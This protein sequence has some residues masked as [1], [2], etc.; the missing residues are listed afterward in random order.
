VLISSHILSEIALTCD[1]VLIIHNGA[2]VYEGS[3]S[4][5]G[6]ALGSGA[7]LTMTLNGRTSAIEEALSASEHVEGYEIGETADGFVM[8]R[9]TLVGDSRE[10]LVASLVKAGVGVRAVQDAMSELEQKFLELTRV[11]G[12]AEALASRKI[13]LLDARDN[14]GE[15]ERDTPTKDDVG[16]EAA[17][18]NA[19]AEADADDKEGEDA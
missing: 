2:I 6:D 11:G 12:T 13:E 9:L 3:E 10:A 18:A 7:R 17:E 8:A 1:R 19:E 14:E 4:Q 16:K 15:V 5:L